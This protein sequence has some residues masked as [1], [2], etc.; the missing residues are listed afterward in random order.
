MTAQGCG[1]GCPSGG[2]HQSL[3]LEANPI[4]VKW[5]LERMGVM[6]GRLRL[7]LTPLAQRHHAAVEARAG[8]G[9][10]SAGGRRLT[11]PG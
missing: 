5:A 2:L 3:F 8:A 6:R 4:P 11:S 1:T 10:N 7:P 9:W